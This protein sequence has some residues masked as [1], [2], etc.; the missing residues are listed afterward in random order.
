MELK[1]AV[2]RQQDITAVRIIAVLIPPKRARVSFNEHFIHTHD[3]QMMEGT[4]ER[5]K[6]REGARTGGERSREDRTGLPN[7]YVRRGE[8][9]EWS[10]APYRNALSSGFYIFGQEFGSD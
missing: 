10:L 7:I 8:R 4:G 3:T 5:E 6:V 2:D 1:D 9:L